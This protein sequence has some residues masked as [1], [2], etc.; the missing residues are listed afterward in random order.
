[1]RIILLL[2]VLVGAMS[3]KYNSLR[4]EDFFYGEIHSVEIP[5]AERLEMQENT[6]EYICHVPVMV[7]DSLAVFY[8]NDGVHHF[9][10]SDLRTK[11]CLGSFVSKGRGP[12]EVVSHQ[13]IYQIYENADGDKS[14][15]VY[16]INEDRLLIWNISKSISQNCTAIDCTYR[17]SIPDDKIRYYMDYFILHDTL[18]VAYMPS[19]YTTVE[20][21]ALTAPAV[22]LVSL[23][24]REVLREYPQFKKVIEKT[25]ENLGF[26]SRFYFR[27]LNAMKPDGTKYAM[28]MGYLPQINILDLESGEIKHCRLKGGAGVEAFAGTEIKSC[29]GQ[30]V[31]DDDYIYAMYYGIVQNRDINISLE[32][33]IANLPHMMHVYDWNGNL[34][35]VLD[36]EIPVTW[37]CVSDGVLWAMNSYTEQLL[38]CTIAD[39]L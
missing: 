4:D 19:D 38:S 15:A 2:L 10:V 30:T 26:E 13:F 21:D 35:K 8:G 29:Y 6:G 33:K 34:V 14:T 24:R 22:R 1:M 31:C 17:F 27:T 28:A 7:C 18:A 9:I 16:G 11:K 3:C 23:P 12:N 32:D 20:K 36:L 5:A 39:K 37:M 25:N